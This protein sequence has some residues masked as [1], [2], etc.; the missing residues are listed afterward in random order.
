MPLIDILI[1]NLNSEKTLAKTLI[2]IKNQSF[3]DYQIVFVDNLSNDS[4]VEIFKNI[5][6]DCNYEIIINDTRL[7]PS[8]NFNKCISLVKSDY[9]CLMHSDDEYEHNYLEVMLESMRDNHE[10][11]MSF[12][13]SNI[14]DIYSRNIF[15]LKNF[16]KKYLFLPKNPLIFGFSGLLWNAYFDKVI[17]PTMFFKKSVIVKYG[18]FSTDFEGVFDWEYIFRILKN[19][20]KI[21]HVNQNLF[22]YRVHNNQQSFIQTKSFKKYLE[23]KIF[24][25]IYTEYLKINHNYNLLQPYICLKICM[26][27]D[28]FLDIL[29]FNFFNAYKRLKFYI[30]LFNW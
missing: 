26:I 2:S 30:K 24:L 8:Q 13:N 22:N 5:N 25:N 20:G 17:C 14:I 7:S 15:S 9:F 11:D 3:K 12:C 16:I 27:K 1:P 21:Y 28:I 29:L 19:N 23:Q 4:S 10:I 18:L 6:F